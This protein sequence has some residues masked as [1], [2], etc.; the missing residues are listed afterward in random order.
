MPHS[1]LCFQAS[2]LSDHRTSAP[3]QPSSTSSMTQ[4]PSTSP[5]TTQQTL[6]QD[7]AQPVPQVQAEPANRSTPPYLTSTLEHIVGQLEILTQVW[8]M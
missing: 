6:T 3:T 2:K 5:G 1:L 4:L 8:T 7:L